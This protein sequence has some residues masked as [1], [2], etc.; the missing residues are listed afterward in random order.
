M[1]E[2]HAEKTFQVE[3]TQRFKRLNEY[4][5]S[6]EGSDERRASIVFIITNLLSQNCDKIESFGI[7]EVVKEMLSCSG[8][9]DPASSLTFY[10]V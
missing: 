7:L 10:V 9:E 8:G 3:V 6:I 5:K 1:T 4:V 2:Y